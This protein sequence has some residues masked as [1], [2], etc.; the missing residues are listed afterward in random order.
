MCAWHQLPFVSGTTPPALQ[1]EAAPHALSSL[2]PVRTTA[3]TA[4]VQDPEAAECTPVVFSQV[5][6]PTPFTFVFDSKWRSPLPPHTWLLSLLLEP[7]KTNIHEPPW[8]WCTLLKVRLAKCW[9]HWMVRVFKKVYI[10]Y[11]N[12]DIFSTKSAQL[13]F[14]LGI[15]I[16]SLE[17]GYG[18]FASI[19]SCPWVCLVSQGGLRFPGPNPTLQLFFASD[20]GGQGSVALWEPMVLGCWTPKRCAKTVCSFFLLRAYPHQ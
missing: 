8:S 5:G 17:S 18:A 6:P 14:E 11:K 19:C 4:F 15:R 12:F 2:R 9:H 10:F 3:L 1:E 13:D 20:P 7:L 16:C